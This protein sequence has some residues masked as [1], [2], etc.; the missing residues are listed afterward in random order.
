M[1]Q[2]R[3]ENINHLRYVD[4]TILTAESEEEIKK[5]LIREKEYSG[6]A[7]LKLN[8]KKS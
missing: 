2:D 8:T 1:N 7:D 6:K 5:F 3:W 4:D